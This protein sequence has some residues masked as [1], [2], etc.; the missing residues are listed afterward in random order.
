MQSV[1]TP[2]LLPNLKSVRFTISENIRLGAHMEWMNN[3]NRP[4]IVK[5]L[6]RKVEYGLQPFLRPLIPRWNGRWWV[7]N[8][9]NG[10]VLGHVHKHEIHAWLQVTSSFEIPVL[11]FDVL[12]MIRADY[13]NLNESKS[14]AGG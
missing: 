10:K 13:R 9:G 7:G 1:H 12:Q 4:I 2:P 3:Y 8:P 14:T 11:V 6:I 5:V